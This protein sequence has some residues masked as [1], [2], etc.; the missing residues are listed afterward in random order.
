MVKNSVIKNGYCIVVASEGVR[1]NNKKFL[2]VSNRNCDAF[3]NIELSGISLILARLVKANLKYKVHWA[4]SDYLQRSARHIA[5]KTDL[6][7]AYEIG[8]F[9]VKSVLQNYNGIMLTIERISSN[10]YNWRIGGVKLNKVANL[11]KHMKAKFI[12]KNGFGITAAFKEYLRPLI[13]GESYPSY[14]NGIP[15]YARLKNILI[16]K[17]LF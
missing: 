14:E 8:K 2:N 15:I 12:S 6:E 7:Q 17:K 13:T 10:P 4:V 16:K 1:N 9:A 5:S 3:G 11:E